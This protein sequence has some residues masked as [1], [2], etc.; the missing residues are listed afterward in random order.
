M[1]KPELK[2]HSTGSP[3]KVVEQTDD[4]TTL[5]VLVTTIGSEDQKD[6][7]EEFFHE[8]TY[9]GTDIVKTHYGTYG[10]GLNHER[11]PH[12][13]QK[14]LFL[15]P[16]T[17]VEQDDAG[18]WFDFEIKRSNA[19]HD[20]ILQLNEKGLLGASTQC[21]PGT[22]QI[23]ADTGR[24]D[25]WIESEVAVLVDP[26]DPKTIGKAMTIAKG[27]E[28]DVEELLKRNSAPGLTDEQRAEERA[29]IL[30]EAG[31][32]EAEE[33]APEAEE[34]P[35]EEAAPDDQDGDE[36]PLA[37][38]IK[39][40]FDAADE[41][42]SPEMT[43]LKAMA[44]SQVEM[45]KELATM[46]ASMNIIVD[47]WGQ[48]DQ[49]P[50]MPSDISLVELMGRLKDLPEIVKQNAEATQEVKAAMKT[51]AVVVADRLK[52]QVAE[53]VKSREGMSALERLLANASEEE[54]ENSSRKGD[55][56]HRIATYLPDNAPGGN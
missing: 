39:A 4:A 18:R 25:T 55:G 56:G 12:A 32:E 44:E 14:N 29:V 35:A 31:L 41:E 40:I 6:L 7:G 37:D 5:R 21:L 1:A 53:T 33:D 2:F 45:A 46:K 28:L 42:L 38:E 49:A 26:M 15:G 11:N 51:F 17:F 36:T 13:D 34:T 24:I 47:I 50:D 30:K 22:K 3:Y 19:Y 43:L 20:Y 10:H 27:L 54:E 8:G 16:A 23:D 9:F 48:L 52:L